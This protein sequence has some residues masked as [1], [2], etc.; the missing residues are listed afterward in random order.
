MILIYKSKPG[1]WKQYMR[2][3]ACV[4]IMYVH[5]YISIYVCIYFIKQIYDTKS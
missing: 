4:Y 1:D 5:M 2:V 3:G